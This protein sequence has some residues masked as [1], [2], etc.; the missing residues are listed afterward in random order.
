MWT[1]L[2]FLFCVGIL[3]VNA[4]SYYDIRISNETGMLE[5][6]SGNTTLGWIGF[7][8]QWIGYA[9]SS[10][11]GVNETTAVAFA[12][13][14]ARQLNFTY[15][16][17][18]IAGYCPLRNNGTILNGGSPVCKGYESTVEECAQGLMA[19]SNSLIYT[20]S[21]AVGVQCTDDFYEDIF[22]PCLKGK[23]SCGSSRTFFVVV[24]NST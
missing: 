22:L 2:L 14:V 11:L 20:Y 12:R 21:L 6:F 16:R 24:P 1:E 7:N 5:V 10:F 8:T 17:V 9:G 4:Q 18:N 15:C 13:V 3:S 23:S 19:Y